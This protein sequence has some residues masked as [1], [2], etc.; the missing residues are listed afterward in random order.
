MESVEF[1]SQQPTVPEELSPAGIQALKR[2]R[3][4]REAMANEQGLPAYVVFLDSTLRTI[5]SKM[6]ITLDELLLISGVRENQV[7]KYGEGI[8]EALA[9]SD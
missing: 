8:L 7:E 1:P 6:P 5:A 3:V 4:W 9:G 2:L